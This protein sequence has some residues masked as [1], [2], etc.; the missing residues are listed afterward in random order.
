MTELEQ[1]KLQALE[2]AL[3]MVRGRRILERNR[4]YMAACDE[5]EVFLEAS[6]ERVNNGE[7]MYS[8]ASASDA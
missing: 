4:S 5:M 1:G 6:I 7:P 3:E 2:Y 8:T